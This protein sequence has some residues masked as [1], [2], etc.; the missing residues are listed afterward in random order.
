MWPATW[1]APEVWPC[2]YLV[3]VWTLSK[4]AKIGSQEMGWYP[5]IPKPDP[6]FRCKQCNWLPW[7]ENGKPVQEVTVG[8][9]Y[10]E[11]VPSFCYFGDTL[12][13]GSDCELATVTRNSVATSSC[14][15]QSHTFSPSLPEQYSTMCQG[16]HAP[17]KWN[18]SNLIRTAS[19]VTPRMIA[20]S[21]DVQCHHWKN[22]SV[23]QASRRNAAWWAGDG[24]THPST[25]LA[26]PRWTHLCIAEES[27]KIQY[28]WKP[29][30][31][32][33]QKNLARSDPQALFGVGPNQGIPFR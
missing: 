2:V 5:G 18:L 29:G 24:G 33:P 31:W 16:C 17:R 6:T 25:Q 3:S 1:C 11:V 19:P 13:E 14:L 28:H 27:P 7:L 20:D 32:S 30:P 15:S 10:P 22:K 4:V 9:K 23:R 26:W 21:L 12:S 8:T